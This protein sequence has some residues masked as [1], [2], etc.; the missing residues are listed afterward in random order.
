M[1]WNYKQSISVCLLAQYLGMYTQLELL[2]IWLS[3]M[4]EICTQ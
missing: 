2:I 3:Y 4:L 1:Y